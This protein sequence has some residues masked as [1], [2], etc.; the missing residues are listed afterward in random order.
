MLIRFASILLL[1][2]IL[3]AQPAL[4][5]PGHGAGD[6]LAGFEHPI[7]GFDHLLAMVA[8]G[9]LALRIGGRALWLLP[10]AFMAGMLLG[11]ALGLLGLPL[12]GVEHLILA[13][14]LLLGLFVAAH[15][16]IPLRWAVPCMT[17]FAV[18]HGHAH[19]AEMAD[20]GAFASYACGFLLATAFLHAA[21]IMAGLALQ[22]GIRRGSLRLAGVVV[23][24]FAVLMFIGMV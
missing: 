17:V 23:S 15:A 14:V 2:L 8:V 24:T 6:F 3:P 19:A 22:R 12:P 20:G 1:A 11:G 9:L 4:A 5:H 7:F 18:F 13:T 10:S 21:G 16:T